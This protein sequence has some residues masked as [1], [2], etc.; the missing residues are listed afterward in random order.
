MERG[1]KGGKGAKNERFK[2][3]MRFKGAGIFLHL[4]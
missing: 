3:N 1:G 4:S 2:G